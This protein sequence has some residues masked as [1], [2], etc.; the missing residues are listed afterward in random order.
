MMLFVYENLMILRS[1][2]SY[3]SSTTSTPSL[4]SD[5]Q[6]DIMHE[7]IYLAFCPRCQSQL[8]QLLVHIL[9]LIRMQIFRKAL[10]ST[11]QTAPQSQ[12][13]LCL[14]SHSIPCLYHPIHSH[15]P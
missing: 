8:F 2:T 13:K 12:A 10:V 3:I 4:A 11:F 1:F 6:F 14:I 9:Q 5:S 7:V 15:N